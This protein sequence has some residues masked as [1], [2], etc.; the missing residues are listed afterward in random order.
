MIIDPQKPGTWKVQL[1]TA[2]KFNF[3]RDVNKERAKQPK[4][5]NKE[6]LT[7]DNSN[8]IVG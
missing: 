2:V 7:D 6:F 1:T 8:D 3:P 4:S 5:D